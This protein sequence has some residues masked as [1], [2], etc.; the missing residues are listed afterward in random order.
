MTINTKMVTVAERMALALQRHGVEHI[1]A[2][3]L[4]SALILAAEAIGIRQIAY[5]Q[6]NMGGAMADGYAR[7]SGKVAVVAA[8]NGP[9][10]TLLVP[11]L[12][13]ALKA[14][15]PLIALVQDVERRQADKNAFQELD[16]I[17]LFQPCAKWVRRVTEADRIEDYLDQAF[18]ASAS[19]RPGPAVL[20][21]PADLLREQGPERPA[22]R[23]SHLGHYPLDRGRPCD[24]VI[25]LAAKLI[26]EAQAPIAIAGEGSTQ[27][28]RRRH[29][30]LSR[31]LLDCRC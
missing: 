30:Q 15:V 28:M 18:V 27:A 29:L 14:S 7:V 2:Q 3:S 5:R 20:L 11:P 4:P 1:F 13:E 9:A 16:H 22:T 19:G 21:L 6:E 31:K 25:A 17:Q 23:R 26:A 24:D 10:A 8:Q 12:A